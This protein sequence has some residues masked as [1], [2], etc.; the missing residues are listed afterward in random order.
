LAKHRTEVLVGTFIIASVL[1]LVLHL[2]LMG[3]MDPV[4]EKSVRLDVDFTDVHG[5]AAGDP[6]YLFGFKVGEVNEI[7]IPPPESDQP[8]RVNVTLSLP[9]R[10]RAHLR[11]DSPVL[12]DKSITGSTMVLIRDGA[13]PP[14]PEG[15]PLKG[16][17]AIDFAAVASRMQQV[18]SNAEEIASSVATVMEQV[19]SKADLAMAVSRLAALPQELREDILPVRDQVQELVRVLQGVV[20][21]NRIDLR[22]AVAN[23]KETSG[24]AKSLTDKLLLTP[25]K[26]ELTLRDLADV[27]KEASAVMRDNRENVDMIMQ[28]LRETST[29]AA[30]RTAE[31]KRRPWR[32]LYRPSEEELRAMEL[33]DSA[34]AYNLGATELN[35]SLRDLM[36]FFERESKEAA[37]PEDLELAY[38]RVRESLRKQREAEET[39]WARLRAS[40]R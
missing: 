40:E 28:D 11:A 10:Y 31:I 30:N 35:R 39:F 29:N 38:E 37:R 33:Y 21:E 20:E 14:L 17:V 13:G 6:V 36:G 9:G 16:R 12:I 26:L 25:E 8:A 18:L 3:T 1:S 34:W 32:I 19:E 27:A 22:H 2:Y 7:E 4:L 23:L 5:L 15:Q 24:Q